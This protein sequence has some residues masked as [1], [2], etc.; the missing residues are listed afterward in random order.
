MELEAIESL[1]RQLEEEKIRANQVNA[2][3]VVVKSE[4]TKHVRTYH[5]SF[6]L[7]MEPQP[8]FWGWICPKLIARG[9]M[10]VT[11]VGPNPPCL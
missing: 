11:D 4:E 1:K 5:P 3:S 9:V 6:T 2:S 10:R 8:A 7:Y